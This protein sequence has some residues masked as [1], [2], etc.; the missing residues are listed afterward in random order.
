MSDQYIGADGVAYVRVEPAQVAVASDPA[1]PRALT[2][3]LRAVHAYI[4]AHPP[5]LSAL[6]DLDLMPEQTLG[7]P[8]WL[9]MVRVVVMY[10]DA[11]G[12]ATP[13]EHLQSW[14]GLADP[15][16]S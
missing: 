12:I 7:T 3:E 14:I 2:D 1:A 16:R 6:Y 8:A 9:R 4:T 5:L 15:L 13:W 11:C 10:A